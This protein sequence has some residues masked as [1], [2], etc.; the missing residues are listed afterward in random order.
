MMRKPS[1]L[2][3][4]GLAVLV[5]VGLTTASCSD[6]S[7]PVAPANAPLVFTAELA[8]A[9]EVP[10]VTNA[11]QTAHGAVQITVTPT[12]DSSGNITAATAKFEIQLAG[13]PTTTTFVGGHIH[14]APAGTTGPVIVNTSLSSG[15]PPVFL[16]G[17][18]TWTFDNINVPV[19]TLQGMIANP[20]SYYFN[21]HTFSNPG[22]VARGQLRRTL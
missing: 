10:A 4:L 8:A 14:P 2:S 5:A 22:G 16:N 18:A 13:L 19:A 21:V 1:I 7:N 11:E 3:G 15:T 9:S 6:D 12:R 17:A 20:G